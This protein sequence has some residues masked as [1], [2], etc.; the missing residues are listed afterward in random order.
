M[1]PEND[2]SNEIADG[3][4]RADYI[5]NG[6]QDH[7]A[8]DIREKFADMMV[9]A[10]KVRRTH[11]E[12]NC[13]LAHMDCKEWSEYLTDPGI[14]YGDTSTI[15]THDTLCSFAFSSVTND[16]LFEHTALVLRN[17]PL[18]RTVGSGL[19]PCASENASA[20]GLTMLWS[21]FKHIEC[22]SFISIVT[23]AA[24]SI[25][26]DHHGVTDFTDFLKLILDI[27]HSS[28]GTAQFRKIETVKWIKLVFETCRRVVIDDPGIMVGDDALKAGMGLVTWWQNKGC[29]SRAISEFGNVFDARKGLAQIMYSVD[30]T[31][32]V[33]NMK[34]YR[35]AAIAVFGVQYGEINISVFE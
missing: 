25:Q 30:Q 32:D 21:E 14:K 9:I 24:R 20:Q 35:I 18:M 13:V 19:Y 22:T 8:N 7:N 4:K 34:V 26:K 10:T 2:Y 6:I 31:A 3:L 5:L 12:R 11:F 1:L 16:T 29:S 15:E 27:E 17:A 28:K 23:A 33:D